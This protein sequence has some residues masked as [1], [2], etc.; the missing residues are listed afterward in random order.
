MKWMKLILPL[1]IVFFCSLLTAQTAPVKARLFT[2]ST[3]FFIGDKITLHAEVE[4]PA[5]YPVKLN[6]KPPINFDTAAFELHG[7]GDWKTNAEQT[8]RQ[9]DISLM[10]WDTGVYKIS[11]AQPDIS[12]QEIYSPFTNTDTISVTISN[13]VDADAMTAPQP[14]KDIIREDSRW[15]DFLP[16]LLPAL[17]ALVIGFIFWRAWKYYKQREKPTDAVAGNKTQRTPK[18]LALQQ[19]AELKKKKYPQAGN[20]KHYY[21]ELSDIVRTYI[22]NEYKIPALENTT[23]ELT[24]ALNRKSILPANT[25]TLAGVLSVADLAKFAKVTP[26]VVECEKDAESVRAFVAGT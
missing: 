9:L 26:S 24:K 5:Q 17:T 21:T 25:K 7:Y 10:V 20:T 12:Q 2:D 23:D 3:H 16:Y 19:L 18:S 6:P 8:R 1:P 14:I 22:E 15:E 11:L 4:T 13:P